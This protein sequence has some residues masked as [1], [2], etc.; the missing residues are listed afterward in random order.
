MNK[1][2]ITEGIPIKKYA[3]FGAFDFI[4]EESWIN[5]M[6]AKGLLLK[7]VSTWKYYF[8]QTGNTTR[9]YRVLPENVNDITDEEK[10]LYMIAGWRRACAFNDRTFIYTDDPDAE[11]LFTDADSYRTYLKKSFRKMIM[12]MLLWLFI[13][14]MIIYNHTGGNWDDTLPGLTYKNMASEIATVLLIFVYAVILISGIVRYIRCKRDIMEKTDPADRSEYNGVMKGNTFADVLCLFVIAI[15]LIQMFFFDD[16]KLS[17]SDA[18]SY[19]GKHP[20]M[21]RE[22]SPDEWGFVKDAVENGGAIR[23]EGDNEILV[24][25]DY[26][27]RK[28]SNF[29]VKEGYSEELYERSRSGVSSEVPSEEI[30]VPGYTALYY[31]FR[32]E[33][34]AEK[35]LN[36][37]IEYEVTNTPEGGTDKTFEELVRI[38][39][40]GVD[41][42]GFYDERDA[43]GEHWAFGTQ[44]LYLRKG[45][46]VVYVSY[47]GKQDLMNNID[48]FVSQFEQE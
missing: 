42:A 4:Y 40:D 38:D 47:S 8:D 26:E 37:Q 27:L 33:K 20:A 29:T 10:E 14:V 18:M 13:L 23:K 3:A 6:A 31:D 34:K 22:L 9:R 7:S 15:V 25:Y 39:V 12:Q 43:D 24:E 45:T 36:E 17:E 16:T 35:M 11:E 28:A 32:S 2:E 46:K 44:Y 21:L 30:A 41:Y 48:L 1:E 5:D 19:S